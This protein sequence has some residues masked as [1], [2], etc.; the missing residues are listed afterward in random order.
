MDVRDSSL[1]VK[2]AGPR[3]STTP[4]SQAGALPKGRV[5]M[6]TATRA[7]ALP[8]AGLF[9]DATEGWAAFQSVAGAAELVC[10]TPAAMDSPG[11]S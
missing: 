3:T 11:A 4:R 7:D 8:T 2:G 1:T 10:L 9:G 6:L 5:D